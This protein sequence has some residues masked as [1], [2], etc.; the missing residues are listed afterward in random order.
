MVSA[1]TLLRRAT[2]AYTRHLVAAV[3]IFTIGILA[4]VGLVVGGVDLLAVIGIEDVTELFPEELTTV[5]IFVNNLQ[6]SLLMVLGGLTLGLLTA[7]A[8]FANGVVVGYVATPAVAE[9]GLFGTLLLLVPH[10]IFELPA[11]FIAAAIGFW[12]A[13]VLTDRI[14][15]RREDLRPDSEEQRRLGALGG[16]AVLLL[17]VAAVVE[18]H[19]TPALFETV[20]GADPGGR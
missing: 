7:F 13:V 6:A 4:G 5:G 14:R 10:G 2:L 3:G 19:V 17:G 9:T 18:V 15:G 1:P 12:I 11:V 20:Y 16:T 8:L